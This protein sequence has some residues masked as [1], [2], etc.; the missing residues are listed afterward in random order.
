MSVKYIGVCTPHSRFKNNDHR[1]LNQAE[2]F[3]KYSKQ[4]MS[5]VTFEEPCDLCQNPI[6]INQIEI[7]F[8]EVKPESEYKKLYDKVLE[9]GMFWEFHPELTGKWEL[10]KQAF[11]DYHTY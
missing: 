5:Y 6:D 8:E 1:W 2:H 4:F 7:D 10:D 3:K 9:I 11:I